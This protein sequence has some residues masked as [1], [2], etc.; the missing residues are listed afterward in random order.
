MFDRLKAISISAFLLPCGLFVGFS[1]QS[2]G[3]K[4]LVMTARTERQ[5]KC[6]SS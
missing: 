2:E 4:A 3:F 6:S 1:V 5:R